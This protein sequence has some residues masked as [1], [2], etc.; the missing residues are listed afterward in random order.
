MSF[1]DNFGNPKGFLGRMMLVS[2][3]KEHLPMAQ[4]ALERIN[5]PGNGKVAD[6][7]CGGGY[8]IRRMLEMS[9]KAKFIGLDISDKSVKKAQKVNKAEIGKRVKVIKG[10]AEKL[11]FKDNSIDLITAFETVFF[12]KKP[13]KAFSEIYRSLVKDGCFAVINNY[14]DPN[15]DW[16]KKVPCMTRYTAEQIADMLKAAGFSD[17]SINKKENL[18][19]VMGYK[20]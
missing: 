7:G 11:S 8:N 19:L 17:I 6:L 2:M 1:T 16:E 13:E 14:G 9:A 4:W 15:V 10:S 18:F 3:D 20:R 12:W 5:I